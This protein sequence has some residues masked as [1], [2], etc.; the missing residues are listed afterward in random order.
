[1]SLLD[2]YVVCRFGQ[3]LRPYNA[4]ARRTAEKWAADLNREN[5]RGHHV[6]PE[7]DVDHFGMC[8]CPEPGRE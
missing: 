3:A 7:R 6:H 1:M 2:F 8:D 5:G 4:F